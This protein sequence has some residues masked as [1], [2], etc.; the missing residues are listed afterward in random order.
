[1]LEIVTHGDACIFL[2][3]DSNDKLVMLWFLNN[4]AAGS[5]VNSLLS[6]N[7]LNT[8]FK[9]YLFSKVYMGSLA[10]AL[11]PYL[12]RV[13]QKED[14]E[15]FSAAFSEWLTAKN[16]RR[17]SLHHLNHA[18]SEI[19]SANHRIENAS[20]QALHSALIRHPA[21]LSVQQVLEQCNTIVHF[22][23]GRTAKLQVRSLGKDSSARVRLPP[24]FMKATGD[25][26][27]GRAGSIPYDRNKVDALVLIRRRKSDHLDLENYQS[28]ATAVV[29][30]MRTSPP[31][32]L[33]RHAITVYS[34]TAGVHYHECDLWSGKSDLVDALLASA[35]EPLWDDAAIEAEREAAVNFDKDYSLRAIARVPRNAHDFE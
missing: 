8:V 34:Y 16:T 9:P 19:P 2:V 5:V 25:W 1:M 18:S 30:P 22:R 15:R 27:N 3:Y 24:K 29:F 20:I 14:R 31:L 17:Y 13:D 12:Y 10:G 6:Y 26:N 35:S 32:D 4:D 7:K 21:V 33:V 11:A 23:D 28:W